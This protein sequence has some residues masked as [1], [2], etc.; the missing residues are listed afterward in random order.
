[1]AQGKEIVRSK[2]SSPAAAKKPKK[3][4]LALSEQNQWI[5]VE[6]PVLLKDL[7]DGLTHYIIPLQ[8]AITSVLE[9]QIQ[10]V[11]G[12]WFN[13][14]NETNPRILKKIANSALAPGEG[15]LGRS[16]DA[17]KNLSVWQDL[18][19]VK[20][21]AKEMQS[22][23]S[24]DFRARMHSTNPDRLSCNLCGEEI[25]NTAIWA[26]I[27]HP[28]VNKEHDSYHHECMLAEKI[29]AEAK[30]FRNAKG[31]L[32]KQSRSV[33]QILTAYHQNP[34][35]YPEGHPD[36]YDRAE[37][38]TTIKSEDEFGGWLFNMYI[39]WS[40][41]TKVKHSFHLVYWSNLQEYARHI[42]AFRATGRV[43]FNLLE[44][45]LNKHLGKEFAILVLNEYAQMI[46]GDKFSG[47]QIKLEKQ[48]R[49]IEPQYEAPQEIM[50]ITPI[51]YDNAVRAEIG[52]QYR[53]GAP[54]LLN[55][56]KLPKTSK[57]LIL[58][59]LA[60]L[61]FGS[62]GNIEQISATVYLVTRSNIKVSNPL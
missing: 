56:E 22:S 1:M 15:G 30:S 41:T 57:Q 34:N 36:H 25:S 37:D 53:S 40:E 26:E 58:D 21:F 7:E 46:H 61:I 47:Y 55:I 8:G 18:T 3:A 33:K 50:R 31:A 10:D 12:D 60:G 44:E 27:W 49:K 23:K 52:H 54:I 4:H 9:S 13:G 24:D 51:V 5:P 19:A 6:I 16:I 20:L 42:L 38:D 2:S 62:P 14:W 48:L 39:S 35:V 59:Y 32:E 45:K 17:V 29:R 11:F 28:A 43:D